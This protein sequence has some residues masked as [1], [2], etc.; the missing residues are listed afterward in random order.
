[1]ENVANRRSMQASHENRSPYSHIEFI[2]IFCWTFNLRKTIWILDVLVIIT[3]MCKLIFKV[4][5]RYNCPFRWP[6]KHHPMLCISNKSLYVGCLQINIKKIIFSSTYGWF[7]FSSLQELF[8]K[9]KSSR[10]VFYISRYGY[11][12]LL[13][14]N[15]WLYTR[16]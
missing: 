15:P 7:Y 8:L 11:Y 3:K 12:K 5:S 10:V 4:I 2:K 14:C 1:M 6:K 9:K 13:V 16:W